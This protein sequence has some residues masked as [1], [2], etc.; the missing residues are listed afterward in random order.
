MQRTE[1]T[2]RGLRVALTGAVG[3]LGQL[4]VSRLEADDAVE[5][6]LALDLERPEGRK[7][8]FH[9]V[10]LLRGDADEELVDALAEKQVDALYHLAFLSRP[11]R[12]GALAHE[13]EVVGSMHVLAAVARAEIP[14]LVVSS[15]TA[16]YGARAQHPALIREDA[17]LHGCAESRFIS[18]RIEVEHQ[19]RAF[20]ERH[21]NKQVLVLRFAPV[22]GPGQDNPATRLLR[23]PIVPTVLGFDPL[24]QAV[25]EKDAARALHACLSA[26]A[27]GEFNVVGEGVLSLSG[28]IR[29]AGAR[30]LPLPQALARGALRAL[31]PFGAG[32]PAPLLDYVQYSWV[33]DG[34][35]AR[36][37]LGFRPDF[38]AHQAA[39]AMR[40]S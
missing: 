12:Q 31:E 33:A 25:H 3:D 10:D 17:P 6:I 7:I 29:E 16:L 4:L 8:D 30:A 39:A 36:D 11:V 15:L 40:R 21:P 9:K 26:D 18:D 38:S 19:V 13:L 27:S 2:P 37:A 23:Q 20:R 14:K 22:L 1:K 34:A 5:S 32:V 35:R 28:M 24:W